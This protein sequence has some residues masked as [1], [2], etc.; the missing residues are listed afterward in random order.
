MYLELEEIQAITNNNN[1]NN[2][3]KLDTIRFWTVQLPNIWNLNCER[4]YVMLGELQRLDCQV[5]PCLQGRCDGDKLAQNTGKEQQVGGGN[6]E[7]E[8][9]LSHTSREDRVSE[10]LC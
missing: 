2:N 3:I 4:E 7:S 8:L 10:L 1:N 5:L 9:L 6:E